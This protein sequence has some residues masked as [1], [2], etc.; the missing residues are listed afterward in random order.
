MKVTTTT[1]EQTAEFFSTFKEAY[2]ADKV[3]G[4]NH[5]LYGEAL[6][7]EQE[8]NNR[9]RFMHRFIDFGAMVWLTVDSPDE[10][11]DFINRHSLKRTQSAHDPELH[12][13]WIEQTLVGYAA[14]KM[15]GDHFL[16]AVKKGRV[17]VRYLL[18]EKVTGDF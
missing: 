10:F 11:G 3:I 15:R 1:I 7:T 8:G 16:I 4:V 17:N 13:V 5:P 2:W 14:I 9:A 12:D 6:R 18:D